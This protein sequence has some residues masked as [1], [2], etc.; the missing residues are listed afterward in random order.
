MT[1]HPAEIGKRV[2]PGAQAVVV[3][4]GAGWHTAKRLRVPAM[5]TWMEGVLRAPAQAGSARHEV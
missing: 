4:D 3:V 2:A 1:L 5:A